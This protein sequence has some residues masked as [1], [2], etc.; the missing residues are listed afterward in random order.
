MFLNSEQDPAV[1]RE[2]WHKQKNWSE[3]SVTGVFCEQNKATNNMLSTT[4]NHR[5]GSIQI[6]RQKD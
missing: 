4:E 6:S 5:C 3:W 2:P 1:E